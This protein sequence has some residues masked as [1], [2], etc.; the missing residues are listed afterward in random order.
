MRDYYTAFADF[1]QQQNAAVLQPW[2][3]CAPEQVRRLLVYRNSSLKSCTQALIANFPISCTL[4][5]QDVFLPLARAFV[6]RCRPVN[7]GLAWYGQDFA[8]WLASNQIVQ[9]YPWLPDLAKLE[10]AWLNSLL[11]VDAEPITPEQLISKADAGVSL[12]TLHL[13]LHPSAQL[14][15]VEHDVWPVLLAA[16]EHPQQVQQVGVYAAR[17]NLLL[18]R[19]P[20]FNIRCQLVYPAEYVFLTALL[21][22]GTSLDLAC[23][24]ATRVDKNLDISHWFAF[25]LGSDLLIPANSEE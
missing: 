12:E 4:L 15:Q 25:L 21:Q 2:L 13:G 10:R 20:S 8:D 7:T 24:A 17:L 23:S 11:A 3:A 9:S 16:R 6:L 19:D 18:W 5:T 14:L 22:H 1:L